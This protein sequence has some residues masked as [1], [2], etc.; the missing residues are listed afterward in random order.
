LGWRRRRLA[1]IAGLA[2]VAAAPALALA[3]DS[4][5]PVTTAHPEKAHEVGEVVVNGMRDS[6]S[7]NGYG[8]LRQRFPG[9]ERPKDVRAPATGKV[10]AAASTGPGR[11][12]GNSPM[13]DGGRVANSAPAH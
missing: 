8:V 12:F 4:D 9:A 5:A 2:L 13:D 10:L 7:Q 11:R 3:A 1:L 6:F